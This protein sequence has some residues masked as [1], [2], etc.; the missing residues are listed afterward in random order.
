MNKGKDFSWL[1]VHRCLF[2]LLTFRILANGIIIC[3]VH[4]PSLNHIGLWVDNLPSAVEWME[5]NGELS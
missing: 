1:D 4:T 3:Q 5:N 2:A